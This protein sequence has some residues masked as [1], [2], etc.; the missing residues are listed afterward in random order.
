MI[1]TNLVLVPMRKGITYFPLKQWLKTR[2][3]TEGCFTAIQSFMSHISNTNLPFISQLCLNTKLIIIQG[4]LQSPNALRHPTQCCQETTSLPSLCGRPLTYLV[5]AELS[6]L[7][8]LALTGGHLIGADRAG[9]V[10]L[11]GTGGEKRQ[12]LVVTRKQ[13]GNAIRKIAI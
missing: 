2:P 8:L 3:N 10:R 4:L 11:A 1:G 5:E 6:D 9:Q 13:G 7:A 12:Q